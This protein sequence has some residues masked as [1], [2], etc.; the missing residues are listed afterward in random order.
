MKKTLI[1]LILFIFAGLLFAQDTKNVPNNKYAKW[2]L[3]SF[4]RGYN[5]L[6]ESP[7]TQQDFIDFKNYGGNLFH[8][9]PDGFFAVDAPYGLVQANI[10]GCD[11]LVNFCRNAGVHYVIGMRSG[12]GAYDT[13][14]ESQGT[15]PESRIWNTGNTTE[16]QKYAEMLQM[17][18]QRYA[19][20][21]LFAGINLVIEPRPKVRVIPANTSALYK[22][23]LENVY[24][25]H[26]DQVYNFWV[27]KIRE[28]DPEIPVII[29]SFGY[30]TPELFPAYV[31]SDPFII[32]SAHDY[33]PNEYTKAET[34]FTMNYPGTY[35]NITFLA[36]KLYNAQFIRETIFGK[37]RDFQI[38][39]GS[40]VFI[41]ELG[42]FKP[43]NGGK[44]FLKD[45]L[46]VC[47]DYG[48]HFAFWDW[49]RGSGPEWN[50]EKFQDTGNEHWKT[51]LA[52][53]HAPPV[54]SPVFPVNGEITTASPVFKWDSLT[55][56]TAYDLK[57]TMFF[58]SRD[59]TF[60]ISDITSAQILLSRSL[61]EGYLYYWQVRAKNPGG[62]PEN[63]SDWSE[64]AY[65]NVGTA[66]DKSENRNN[67]FSLNQNSP[68]PFNPS[69]NISFSL[70]ENS[71]VKLVVYDI[72]GREI[73]VLAD[74]NFS[75]GNH[76][77][78]F[79][80]S[81]LP[82]GVYFYRLESSPENS[83]RQFTEI[84]RMILVK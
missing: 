71:F 1:L 66:T 12:P 20:D 83:S 76:S 15:V 37:L 40:P 52:K 2:Q 54:P 39:T 50:I 25:I 3:S 9:Q 26:M 21:T 28:V 13:F 58:G 18:V 43:Q 47:T 33:Q 23:F 35:W 17:V 51:V 4:F 55:A 22:F 74:D 84:K 64:P 19:N 6:Y 29:E 82:S 42:M 81:S 10:D 8:I 63:W 61:L 38:Q 78:L 59:K 14:D 31:I 11:M 49:R 56:F 62:N 72:T 69:T 44:D 36:Q 27:S 41:G 46:D 32:Y 77:V 73:S 16:Q 24:N 79:N 80:A 67:T 60:I 30:S 48:W 68:N 34:P 65:F 53:F 75:A 7:K 5:V 45:V 70:P 57:V